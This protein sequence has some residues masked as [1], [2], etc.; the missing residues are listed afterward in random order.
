MADFRRW[1]YAFAVVAL[2][3]GLT[4]PASAQITPFVCNT[5]AGVPPI[6]RA[7]AYADLVGDLTLACTG[8]NSTVVGQV[9]PQVNITIFLSTNITSKLLGS[10]AGAFNEA[11]LIIDE[12]NAT[13]PNSNRPILNCGNTG[14][15]DNGPSG[16]GVCQITSI[17]N[18]ANTYDGTPN[19]WTGGFTC[20]GVGTRP[21]P[22]SYG[23]GRPNVFQGRQGIQQNQGQSNIVTFLGV[24]L[25]PPGT[26]TT[27]T[28][29]ITNV[30]ADAEFVGVASTF[31]QLPIQMQISVNGNTSLLIN[32]PT[33]VVAYI[34]A[35]LITTV[36]NP[37]LDFVQCNTENGA[38]FGGKAFHFDPG[39][40]NSGDCGGANG[41]GGNS[42]SGSPVVRFAEGF[43]SSWKE[44]NI[45]H[46][47]TNGTFTSNA[48][49]FNGGISY[50]ADLTQN[51]PGALYNTESGF[52]YP[53]GI[54]NPSPN[55][56]PG[57]GNGPVTGA[58]G[59]GYA[60]NSGSGTGISGAG[61]ATQGTRLALSF[62]SIPSGSAVFVPPVIFLFRQ[63]TPTPP[64][65][66]Y[67][68]SSTGVAVLTT[69]DANGDT[70]YGAA[71]SGLPNPV[72]INTVPGTLVQVSNNLAV[73]EV[74]FDDPFSLEQVDVPVVVAFV[75]NLSANPPGGLPQTGVIAQINGSFAPFYTTASAR[76]PSATLP[77]PRFK[78]GPN[79]VNLFEINKCACDILF[80]FVAS[81]GGFDTGIAVA[82]TSLDPGATYGFFAT[83]QQGSVT[84]WY[85]GTGLNGG[86]PPPSQTSLNVPAGQ[87]LTYVLSNGGGAIGNGPNGLTGIAA[88]F[89]GYI[90][91]Q[92]Q[93][94]YCHAFAFISPLG[95]GP[96]SPGVSEGYL[97]LILDPGGLVRTFQ[98]AEVLV[99]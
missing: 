41:G 85:F 54:A 55:P 8:G 72:P 69:T 63:G 15:P 29:R 13:G 46:H 36:R 61:V 86:Q 27:R 35:G 75:S 68:S 60:F 76:Q 45:V 98:T 81:V 25:D 40:P 58:T 70:A 65:A 24:P 57:I 38:L 97:G 7:E 4:V 48:W 78:P 84:F 14:A 71:E 26:G 9:I 37:R 56:P 33:Q 43:A 10:A 66:A 31:Q 96:A 79:V 89:E 74:L 64:P 82:N 87:V 59:T 93:F 1:F 53:P 2:L 17:G 83:P 52:M 16:P 11:L 94:Q 62:S 44:K 12:P 95:G 67:V 20:D 19:G 50:P 90:I 21:A 23:C 28:L 91:A 49:T 99:H 42:G 5:N 22:G 39:C 92:A 47:I 32:N 18:P 34:Q 88:G 80:P 77:V 6:V 30:R 73:Y 51:V 3:T